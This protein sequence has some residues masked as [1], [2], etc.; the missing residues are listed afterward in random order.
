MP[1]SGGPPRV[2]L[3]A[4]L[5]STLLQDSEWAGSTQVNSLWWQRGHLLVFKLFFL[6]GKG[7]GFPTWQIFWRTTWAR[8][9]WVAPGEGAWVSA[10]FPGFAGRAPRC[11]SRLQETL[12]Q[13]GLPPSC[14][15]IGM[16][17]EWKWPHKPA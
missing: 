2:G 13:V 11:L 3:G 5:A 1:L 8:C 17:A 16:T 14:P 6:I 12:E 4:R 10:P 15:G 7:G 9:G